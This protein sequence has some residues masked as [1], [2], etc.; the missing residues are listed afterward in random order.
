MNEKK[1]LVL[2]TFLM[3]CSGWI[4]M[5]QSAY[6]GETTP[7]PFPDRLKIWGGYQ[8]LFGLD[9]KVRL[10]GSKTGAGTTVDLD[11][12]L[13]VD[14]TDHMIRAGI[15]WRFNPR[16]AIGFSYY[17]MEFEGDGKLDQNFQ[18]DDT[19]FQVGATTDSEV[20]LA[21]YRL[22]YQ[23]SFYHSEKAELS[24]SPGL[25]FGDFEATFQGNL[26]IQPGDL[27]IS[28]RKSTI[29]EDLFAPLPTVGFAVLYKIFPRLTGR[30]QTDYFYVDIDDIEGSM[31][32]LFIGLEY[33]LFDHF[34][35]GASYNRLWVDV[36]YKSGKS[37]GFD[38]DAKWNG[39][40]GYG[41]IYF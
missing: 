29:K 30:L 20:E 23:Y 26:T 21:L 6:G 12:D 14:T 25:Y 3:I 13:D 31:A 16:H 35:L 40:M 34:G 5:G 36:E 15:Q 2:G 22:Y 41:A 27:P 7:S 28:S 32:E 10:D 11:E 9:A 18:I 24:I 17:D 38:I 4:L 39:V 37:G 33:R 1:S 8:Y 19:I